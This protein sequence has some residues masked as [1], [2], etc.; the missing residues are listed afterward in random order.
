VAYIYT[1]MFGSTAEQPR[2]SKMPVSKN[3][4]AGMVGLLHDDDCD[5][6]LMNGHLEG[7][8]IH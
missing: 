8:K 6:W 5:E 2:R 4:E 3:L 7:F 1:S